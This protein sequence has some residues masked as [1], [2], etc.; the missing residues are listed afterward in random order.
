MQSASPLGCRFVTHL[1]ERP[2]EVHRRRPGFGQDAVGGVEILAALGR[3]RVAVRGG[4]A[5]GRRPAH[6]ERPDRLGD[7]GR[8]LAAE[9]ELLVRKP[10]LVEQD[11]RAGLQTNDALRRQVPSSHE[12]RYFACSSVS[13]S[14]STPM[15]ASLSRAIS[16]SISSGTT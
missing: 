14:M 4:D 2:D 6:G 9:L 16:L 10:A 1:L 12:A 5:D 8:R 11:D 7:L 15:V 3:E 13:R